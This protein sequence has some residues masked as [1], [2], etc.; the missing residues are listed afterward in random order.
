MR[1]KV[2]SCALADFNAVNRENKESC[3][4]ARHSLPSFHCGFIVLTPTSCKSWSVPVRAKPCETQ[5][6]TQPLVEINFFDFSFYN[7]LINTH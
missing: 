6:F 2:K 4:E 1:H 5:S 3:Q 7:L